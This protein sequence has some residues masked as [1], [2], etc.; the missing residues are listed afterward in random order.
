METPPTLGATG[1]LTSELP[2]QYIRVKVTKACKHN[3]DLQAIP[4]DLSTIS[5]HVAHVTAKKVSVILR[6]ENKKAIKHKQ[7]IYNSI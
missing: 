5:H 6:A 2:V 1:S 3:E 4:Q 7:E